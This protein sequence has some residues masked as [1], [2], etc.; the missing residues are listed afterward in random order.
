LKL[1]TEGQSVER[2][3]GVLRCPHCGGGLLRHLEVEVFT[4]AE[5]AAAVIKTTTASD[6][7]ARSTLIANRA[8]GNPSPCGGG[9]RIKL[10]CDD[11]DAA[12]FFLTLG[13]HQGGIELGWAD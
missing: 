3:G 9:L 1:S 6:G 8:S 10:T 11:C 4:H 13:R 5:G 12:P 2:S 7:Q